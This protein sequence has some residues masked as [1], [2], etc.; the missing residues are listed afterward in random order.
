[1]WIFGFFIVVVVVFVSL[2]L[3]YLLKNRGYL[4]SIG[5]PFIK[6][7][8]I[9]G[10]PPFVPHKI[11]VHDFINQCFKKYG[12]TWARYDGREAAIYTI[13]PHLIKSIM[14]KN[15]DNFS[16]I[17]DWHLSDD[18][19]TLDLAGGEK[20]KALRRALSPMFTSAKLKLMF[21]PLEPILDNLV[22][23]LAKESE[24]KELFN[25]TEIFQ[26]FALESIAACTFGI[27]TNSIEEFDNNNILKWAKAIFSGFGC[28]TWSDSGFKFML[29]HLTFLKQHFY[30]Y[31]DE[32]KKLLG[33][34]K[35]IIE[36]RKLNKIKKEDLIGR[37][38]E[39]LE[40]L[41]PPLTEELVLAQGAI[42]FAAGFE[43]MS[44]AL[45]TLCYNLAKN[46]HIQVIF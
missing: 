6:P 26:S 35:Q 28:S 25:L 22:Q 46:P 18:K 4:E 23:Y 34:A 5:V 19:I 21:E 37:L 31:P 15:F 16:D 8:L 38:M 42:F 30:M 27:Q 11:T 13:D 7:V 29:S 33:V 14:I 39:I 32:L 41:E 40:S 10:S 43:T 12:K 9:F 44:K 20:W 24:R 2:T 3:Q 45:A 36:H 1:M 17:I